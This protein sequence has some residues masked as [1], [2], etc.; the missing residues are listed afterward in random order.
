M[1][2]SG[3]C[4]R[5][6]RRG[7]GRGGGW[8]RGAFPPEGA[9]AW[10]VRVARRQWARRRARG[11]RATAQVRACVRVYA[12]RGARGRRRRAARMHSRL[13]SRGAR[14]SRSRGSRADLTARRALHYAGVT[15]ATTRAMNSAGRGIHPRSRAPPRRSFTPR[16]GRPHSDARWRP[17]SHDPARSAIFHSLGVRTDGVPRNGH[18]REYVFGAL[19]AAAAELTF[20]AERG[21]PKRVADERSAMVEKQR[22][23]H[24]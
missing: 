18:V 14:V 16:R 21:G 12:F 13:I 5:E 7:K 11:E 24:L 3:S 9:A 22:Q 19:R 15:C 10:R 4:E 2:V 17:R 8:C 20:D 6:R 23:H 1:R